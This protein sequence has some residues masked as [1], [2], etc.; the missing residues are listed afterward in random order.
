[1]NR[2]FGRSTVDAVVANVN[3]QRNEARRVRREFS[4]TN[5]EKG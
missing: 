1:M 4:M 2:I 5:G 3:R